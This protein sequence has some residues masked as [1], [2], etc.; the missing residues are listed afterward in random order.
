[1]SDP[2]DYVLV[3][4]PDRLC[5]EDPELWFALGPR[6][7][8]RAKAICRRCPYQASC[9]RTALAY[10]ETAG[11][12]GGLDP[13]ERATIQTQNRPAVDPRAPCAAS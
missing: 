7:I 5:K 8:A 3:F 1:M 13:D 12:W 9:L 10:Q 6:R 2:A 11:I 4:V